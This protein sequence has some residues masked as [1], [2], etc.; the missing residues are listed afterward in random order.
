MRLAG[1]IQFLRDNLITLRN[2]LCAYLM[3]IIIFDFLLPRHHPHLFTDRLPGFW[4]AF[5][6]VGC[7]L[8]IKVSK[9][10][11]HLFLSKK[12]GYYGDY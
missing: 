3:G 5:G 11:A 8:L 9:G 4:T 1:W 7:F 12:E 6:I 10:A 2:I